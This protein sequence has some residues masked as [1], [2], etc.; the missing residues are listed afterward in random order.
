MK[1]LIITGLFPPN[2]VGGYEIACASFVDHLV[3]RGYVVR[4]L[5]ANHPSSPAPS[6]SQVEIHRDLEWYRAEDLGFRS[7]SVPARVH[8]ERRNLSTLKRHLSAF[9]PDVV[10]FWAMGGM[11]ISLIESVRRTGVPAIG[12]VSDEWML[13]GTAVD[14]WLRMFRRLPDRAGALARPL[15]IPTTVELGAA[16]TWSFV[17]EYLRDAILEAGVSLPRTTIGRTG[18][19]ADELAPAG[20]GEVGPFGDTLLYVGRVTRA[21]G[22]DVAV[23]ALGD[24]PTGY[25]LRI[26][27]PADG[28]YEQ[29]LDHVAT[30]LGV[31]DR[32]SFEPA[33]A[34]SALAE[35]YRRAAALLFPVRWNEPW[36][37]VPL[38]AMAC[39]T[40][41]IATGTGG[42]SEYLR[43]EDNCL[44]VALDDHRAVARSVERLAGDGQLRGAL[45]RHGLET[46]A[47]YSESECNT[48]FEAQ[49]LAAAGGR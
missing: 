3:S 23:R 40:P 21:K 13:Y 18:I 12:M 1:V 34:R 42:S 16:A 39:G 5:A 20:D 14:A 22:V 28:E 48:A 49:L 26:V 25:R 30:D 31:R 9:A 2:H 15:G 10:N 8:L 38:E 32:I 35:C 19:N 29:E 7:P 46:A 6:Q 43:H 44:L 27:G 11:S 45:R 41:V 24:L 36:G 17:S 37:L 47:R 33:L 4:V